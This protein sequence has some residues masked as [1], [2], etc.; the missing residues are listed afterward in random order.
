[1][2]N[3]IKQIIIVILSFILFLFIQNFDD[4]KNKI[5]RNKTL[6]EK[7]KNKILFSIIIALALNINLNN[8]CSNITIPI[9]V[10]PCNL[11]EP[12]LSCNNS[13]NFFDK[14]EFISYPP[15]F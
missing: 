12:S 15:P 5:N 14:D 9:Y 8:L 1:M 11:P 4:K 3:Y 2:H 13:N 7:Y 10:E 6:Y